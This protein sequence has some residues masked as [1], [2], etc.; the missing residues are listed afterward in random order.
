MPIKRLSNPQSFHLVAV[1]WKY[2]AHPNIVPF[3]GVTTDPLQL[4]S[5]WMSGGDLTEYITNYPGVNRVC[6]V[7]VPCTSMYDVPT[8]SPDI[9]CR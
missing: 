9:R 7:R 3:L 1:M 8:T 6:L 2:L 4:V 5:E